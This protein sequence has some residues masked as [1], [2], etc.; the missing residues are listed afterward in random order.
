V[1]ARTCWSGWAARTART[2]RWFG[3]VGVC[4]SDDSTLVNCALRPV[5]G[6]SEDFRILRSTESR[7][8]SVRREGMASKS[9]GVNLDET[10]LPVR[11][12]HRGRCSLCADALRSARDNDVGGHNACAEYSPR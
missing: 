9:P 4:E 12:R 3:L 7:R 2:V 6:V 5:G 11:R 10:S 1:S 8:G